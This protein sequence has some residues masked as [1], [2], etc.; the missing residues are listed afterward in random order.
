MKA[1]SGYVLLRT[2]AWVLWNETTCRPRAGRWLSD[3]RS[4]TLRYIVSHITGRAALRLSHYSP[5]TADAP[6][7]AVPSGQE[8]R[9][10]YRAPDGR[11]SLFITA[12]CSTN[13]DNCGVV[14]AV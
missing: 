8:R 10:V 3:S 11:R 5:D 9:Q 12:I 14:C 4:L 2:I 13:R 1:P 6:D 7:D